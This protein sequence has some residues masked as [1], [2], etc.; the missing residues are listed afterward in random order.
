MTTSMKVVEWQIEK[1]VSLGTLAALAA[2]A[3]SL[4]WFLSG[5]AGDIKSHSEA[6]TKI[7]A[8]MATLQAERFDTNSR[9]VRI[10]TL[11]TQL[12]EESRSK[13]AEYSAR[14]AAP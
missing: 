10:E 13:R 7:N 1:R 2:Q 8:D 3:I 11:F 14:P 9:L 6:I 12:L 4:V 5:M